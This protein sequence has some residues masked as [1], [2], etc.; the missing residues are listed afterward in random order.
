MTT[1]ETFTFGR[2]SGVDRRR[3]L[4]TGGALASA[5]VLMR[6]AAGRAAEGLTF[7]V[8]CDGR[9]M[10]IN[11]LNQT[12]AIGLPRRGDTFVVTGSIY[13]AGTIDAGLT[14]P[15]QAGAIGRWTCRGAFDVDIETGAVPHVVSSVLFTFGEGLT[16]TT[17]L[18]ELAEDAI[19]TDGFEGGVEEIRRVVVGGFGRYAGIRGEQIQYVRGENDTFLQIAPDVAVPAPNFTFVFNLAE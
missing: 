11:R 3:M 7:D 5:A 18:V 10:L 13:P 19:L 17:G 8:A 16:A 9:T 2:P 12:E 14:G 15:D 1:R 4:K 6:A